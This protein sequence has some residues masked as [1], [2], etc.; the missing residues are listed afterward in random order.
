MLIN[1]CATAG[2]HAVGSQC[3]YIL[4]KPTPG[5]AIARRLTLRN[6]SNTF[7]RLDHEK[8]E[9]SKLLAMAR[10]IHSSNAVAAAFD[11]DNS[12]EYQQLV[13]WVQ[14]ATR[15]NRA[16]AAALLQQPATPQPK[17][18][19]PIRPQTTELTPSA[20]GTAPQLQTTAIPDGAGW[21]HAL[22]PAKEAAQNKVQHPTADAGSK[23]ASKVVP[24]TATAP[25][26]AAALA[27]ES[28]KFGPLPE[29][30]NPPAADTQKQPLQPRD[31]N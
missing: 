19:S 28:K 1:H 7:A 15:G 6:L 8:P 22:A 16:S 18:I 4:L 14:F 12:L 24:A 21:L 11:S 31:E 25:I 17:T 26:K 9:Q 29:S 30:P 23:P 3:D 13:A 5:M 27:A 10:E 20:P 2:C